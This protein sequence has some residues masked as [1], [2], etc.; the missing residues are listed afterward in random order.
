MEVLEALEAPLLDFQSLLL[1]VLLVD[2]KEEAGSQKLVN[3]FDS[4]NLVT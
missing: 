4:A 3:G 2:F 1:S